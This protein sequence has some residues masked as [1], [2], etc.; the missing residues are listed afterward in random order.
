MQTQIFSLFL[1]TRT[2]LPTQT[3][4]YSFLIKPE[5]ISFL[6]SDWIASIISGRNRRCCCLTG[7]VSGLMF[8][9]YIATCY[10]DSIVYLRYCYKVMKFCIF[11]VQVSTQSIMTFMI[12]EENSSLGHASFRSRKSM[13]SQIFSFFLITRMILATQLGCC[14]SLIKPESKLLDL[15]LDHFYYYRKEPSLLLLDRPRV[16]IDVKAMHNHLGVKLGYIFVV[17][18]ENIY[19][20]SHDIY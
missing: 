19:I 12:G 14:S 20:V 10:I 5:S 7:F 8:R 11:C 4:C 6:T 15:W 1:V 17:P 18:G 16:W 9:Q 13:Q 3:G 2:I